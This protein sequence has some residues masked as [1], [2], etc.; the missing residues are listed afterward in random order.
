M[1]E[2]ALTD[3]VCGRFSGG[4]HLDAWRTLAEVLP[5]PVR[6]RCEA[7]ALWCDL[8]LPRDIA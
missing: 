4:E 3:A 1:L 7:I 6:E 8:G 5:P 2:V